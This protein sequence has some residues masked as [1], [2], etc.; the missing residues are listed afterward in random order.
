MCQC[1]PEV[2]AGGC[3]EGRRDGG[4]QVGRM[5]LN[6]SLPVPNPTL[7]KR[8]P[9]ASSL[10][11]PASSSTLPARLR[12]PTPCHSPSSLTVALLRLANQYGGYNSNPSRALPTRPLPVSS[13]QSPVLIVPSSAARPGH[14][15]SISAGQTQLA[16]RATVPTHAPT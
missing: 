8:Q 11:P 6:S 12:T 7:S 15:Q 1:V 13:C 16:A 14:R 10:Q 3:T 4:T 5:H 9:P 2:A